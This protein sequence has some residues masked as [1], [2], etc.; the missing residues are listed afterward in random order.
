MPDSSSGSS[1]GSSSSWSSESASSKSAVSKDDAKGKSKDN[2]GSKGSVGSKKVEE[3]NPKSKPPIARPSGDSG[4][5]SGNAGQKG[6]AGRR[7]SSDTDRLQQELLKSIRASEDDSSEETSSLDDDELE[8]ID[9]LVASKLGIVKRMM[10]SVLGP[11]RPRH[12]RRSV[13]G[14]INSIVK[15][16]KKHPFLFFI[17]MLVCAILLMELF[18]YMTGASSTSRFPCGDA[19]AP[20]KSKTGCG[21]PEKD[22]IST[23]EIWQLNDPNKRSKSKTFCDGL[24]WWECAITKISMGGSSKC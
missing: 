11:E 5:T 22:T 8:E 12:V 10:D 20:R 2:A 16:A 6:N 7:A 15:F 3:T 24:T 18:W 9:R 14:F 4:G 19:N 13:V 21:M 23:T 1:S 17:A